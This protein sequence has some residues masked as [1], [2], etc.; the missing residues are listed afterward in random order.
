MAFANVFR[1]S[2]LRS[3]HA[4]RNSN[5]Q[6]VNSE[7]VKM[8]PIQCLFVHLRQLVFKHWMEFI[9]AAHIVYLTGFERLNSA[10]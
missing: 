3:F 8:S 4:N 7:S 1:S 9:F 2:F 10:I 5:T 6:N